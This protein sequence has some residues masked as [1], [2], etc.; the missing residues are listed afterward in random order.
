MRSVERGD[1]RSDVGVSEIAAMLM[2]QNDPS[3]TQPNTAVK[4]PAYLCRY[5]GRNILPFPEFQL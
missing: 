1:E 2:I 4:F 5:A 3:S